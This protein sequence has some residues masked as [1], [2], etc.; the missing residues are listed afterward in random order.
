MPAKRTPPPAMKT[1]PKPKAQAKRTIRMPPAPKAKP[2]RVV[3]D[4]PKYTDPKWAAK[5]KARGRRII[6][7]QP[8]K[9]IGK[10]REGPRAGRMTV[11]PDAGGRTGVVTVGKTVMGLLNGDIDIKTWTDEELI[12]GAPRNVSRVPNVIP[13]MVYTELIRRMKSRALVKWAK[14][15]DQVMEAHLKIALNVGPDN[16]PGSGTVPY[17]VQLQAMIV[18]EERMLGK[19]M[20]HVALHDGEAPWIRAMAVG[21]VGTPEQAAAAIKERE[22][23]EATATKRD[24]AEGEGDDGEGD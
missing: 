5:S 13:L 8:R 11:Y 14:E 19:P 3:D 17:G 9:V 10:K 1:K 4:R 12:R 15:L 22:A 7:G 2:R 24:A 6:E 21:I 16:K 18:I 23:I 20:E